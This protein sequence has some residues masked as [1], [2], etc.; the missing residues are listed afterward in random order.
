MGHFWDSVRQS[1][2][3]LDLGQ[4]SL[5]VPSSFRAA[6]SPVQAVNLSLNEGVAQSE[7]FLFLPFTDEEIATFKNGGRVFCNTRPKSHG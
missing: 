7:D 5:R 6:S 2:V 1:P 3:K 4:V